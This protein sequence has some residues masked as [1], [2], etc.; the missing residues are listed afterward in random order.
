MLDRLECKPRQAGKV[1]AH[2]VVCGGVVPAVITPCKSP[3]QIDRG[4]MARL[5]KTFSQ[6]KCRG[7]F[8]IGSTGEMFLLDEDD[9]RALT[10]AAREGAGDAMVY[11]GI[12]GT[13]LKQVI[14]YARYAAADG[15]DVAV[16]MVPFS[17]KFSQTEIY[18]YIRAVADASPIPVAMY[19]HLRMPTPI[20]VETVARLAQHGNVIAI[21]DSSTDLERMKALVAAVRGTR[22]SVMQGC[23][24]LLCGSLEAGANG[25]VSA[26]GNI[27]PDWHV[28]LLAAWNR[29]DKAQA[30]AWQDRIL[31]LCKLFS[32]EPLKLSFSNFAYFLKRGLQL[33][34]WLENTAPLMAGYVP[35]SAFDE[36]IMAILR[37]A[38][39]EL[40]EGPTT[41]SMTGG[42]QPKT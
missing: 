37:D 3:G 26:L 19:H 6:Q 1:P 18:D 35:D 8:V 41:A 9:R 39:P 25:C 7:V 17:V 15:A 11:A 12:S 38:A 34:G 23:E 36:K 32:L 21:K 14:R 13:G 42:E 2:Q 20:E 28:E 29:G 40:F 22:V 27:V 4:A 24:N 16:F 10:E 30:Q 31:G 33:H 5:C